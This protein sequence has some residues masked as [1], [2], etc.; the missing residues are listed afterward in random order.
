MTGTIGRAFGAPRLT[1]ASVSWLGSATPPPAV[2]IVAAPGQGLE[3]RLVRIAGRLDAIHKLGDRWRAELI[4]GSTPDPARRADR[5]PD[6]RGEPDCGS[7]GHGRRHRPARL[8]D[9]DR[10]AVCDRAALHLRPRIRRPGP[11]RSHRQADGRV[12]GRRRGHRTGEPRPQPAPRPR[13]PAG[14]SS[15]CA[16]WPPIAARRSGS[17]ASSPP[18]QG[19]SSRSTMGRHRAG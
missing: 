11:P 15:T 7:P 12:G 19:R 18:W 6:P 16:T 14:R 2:E 8:S 10:P 9:G 5:G 1:V 3:W 17:P 4:V 13:R